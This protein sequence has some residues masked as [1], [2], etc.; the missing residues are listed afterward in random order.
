[1]SLTVIVPTFNESVHLHR[2]LES[3]GRHADR[4]VVLDSNSTDDTVAIARRFEAHGVSVVQHAYAGP[5]D[6]KNW[7][8]DHLDIQTDWVLFLD[9]DETITPELWRE[10][11]DVT[12]RKDNPISGYFL[13]R[14]IVWYGKWIRFG[15]WF[16]NWNLRLFRFGRARYEQRRVHEHMLVDGGVASLQH[17][18]IHEDLRDLTHSIAK[19]NRY[20]SHEALEYQ[21]ALGGRSDGYARFWTRDR[22]A[23][24]RWIKL[25]LWAPLPGK[26]LWYF[27]WC[28]FLR[29]GFLDGVYGLRYHLMHAMFKHFDECK[30][31]ELQNHKEPASEGTIQV[32]PTYWDR[33]RERREPELTATGRTEQ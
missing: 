8:L 32:S 15:G 19:H 33:Y 23:R 1:M 25:H 17:H 16:P 3:L 31:W 2:C 22:L 12:R 28:Y 21:E 18:L 27:L 5:A 6:Q 4:V 7:A 13:N 24:R 14:R 29:L 9:A 11:L 30:L 26:A 20:S 10:I